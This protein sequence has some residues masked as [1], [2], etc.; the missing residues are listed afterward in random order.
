MNIILLILKPAILL[1]I[2]L[3]ANYYSYNNG[4]QVFPIIMCTFSCIVLSGLSFYNLDKLL[5]NRNSL[6]FFKDQKEYFYKEVYPF[7]KNKDE[8][9]R[10]IEGLNLD[11]KIFSEI[12]YQ[13]LR[14]YYIAVAL[15]FLNAIYS[16]FIR[17]FF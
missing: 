5:D 17:I 16:V 1:I 15:L 7:I 2:T 12:Y 14:D 9:T 8:I 13:Y 3:F 4:I 10:S 11:I 6:N